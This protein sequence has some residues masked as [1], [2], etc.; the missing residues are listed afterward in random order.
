MVRIAPG[1]GCMGSRLRTILARR[2]MYLF[3]T[4][5]LA[6]TISVVTGR[7][8]CHGG[9]WRRHIMTLD[10]RTALYIIH[11]PI[12]LSKSTCALYYCSHFS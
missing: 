10:V 1:V 2:S 11:C 8:A 3:S 9:V 4:I 12:H 5:Y 6:N 7:L